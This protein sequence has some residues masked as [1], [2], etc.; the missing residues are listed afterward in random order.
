[1]TTTTKVDRDH[2]PDSKSKE[3]V[4]SDNA[5]PQFRVLSV[6]NLAERCSD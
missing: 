4:K 2:A 1:V 6:K 3:T 5:F